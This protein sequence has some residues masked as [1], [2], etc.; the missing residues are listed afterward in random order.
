MKIDDGERSLV[1]LHI[2][3]EGIL[4][5]NIAQSD[6]GAKLRVYGRRV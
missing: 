2:L 6:G 3:H 5:L 4:A 1:F